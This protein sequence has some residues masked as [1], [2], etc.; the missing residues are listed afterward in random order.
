[1]RDRLIE[2]VAALAIAEGFDVELHWSFVSAVGRFGGRAF[3]R[4][5]VSAVRTAVGRLDTI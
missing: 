4:S 5:G 2:A 3:R 1:M